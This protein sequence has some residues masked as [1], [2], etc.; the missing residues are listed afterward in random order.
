MTLGGERLHEK[1]RG[2]CEVKDRLHEDQQGGC[3]S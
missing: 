3:P 2:L 1:R